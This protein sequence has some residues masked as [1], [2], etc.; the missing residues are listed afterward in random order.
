[1]LFDIAE[2][3]RAKAIPDVPVFIDSP[4]ASRA[5]TV[6][7]RHAGELEDV[8][9]ACTFKAP[10]FHFTENVQESI[11][12][13]SVSGAIIMA[14]SGM[15]EAG[16]IRHHLI[17]NLHRRE[18]TVLFVGFQAAGTLGRVIM[19]GAQRVRISGEDVI[20]RAA[21]RRLDSYSAH[22]DQ[23]E[24][25]NWIAARA[26]IAGSL[27]LIHGEQEALEALRQLSVQRLERTQVVLPEIG[28][29]YELPPGAPARRTQTGRTDLTAAL[30][31]D[32]QNSYAQFVTGLKRDLAEIRDER[33]RQ[34]AIA[35][36]REVLDSY[37]RHR[38]EKSRKGRH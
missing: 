6:F 34:Q 1:L 16:R 30:G 31:H 35:A 21:I 17:H 25:A 15:C 22:A 14:A 29:V 4:L 27:F 24:L 23:G 37:T 11:R 3:V 36:M 19:E 9:P 28:E 20:V 13:N 33:Q 5:T 10:N 38:E 2:L 26:P 32:W 12:L 7:Q 8:D 18:S